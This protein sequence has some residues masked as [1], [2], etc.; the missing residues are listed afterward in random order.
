MD[1]TK[2]QFKEW[3]DSYVTQEFF[4]VLIDRVEEAKEV[5]S[6]SAGNSQLD[7][8]FMAGMIHAFREVLIVDWEDK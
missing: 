8:R 7:D 4:K 5:L 2:E 1:V 3:K 6:Y